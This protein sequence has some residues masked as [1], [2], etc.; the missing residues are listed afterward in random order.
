MNKA[1][2]VTVVQVVHPATA[3]SRLDLG[4]LACTPWVVAH[5]NIGEY[6][7]RR[8]CQRVLL[9]SYLEER[10]KL[11]RRLMGIACQFQEGLIDEMLSE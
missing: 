2:L 6:T 3:R 7:G 10:E 5:R 11:G 8:Y 1:Q 9:R 4:V